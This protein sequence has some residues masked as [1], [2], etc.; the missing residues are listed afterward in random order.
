[1]GI[2]D[3][4]AGA[5]VGIVKADPLALTIIVQT[6]TSAIVPSTKSNT[7]GFVTK[8]ADRDF[9]ACPAPKPNILPSLKP[10]PTC[11]YALEAVFAIFCGLT[12]A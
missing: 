6:T 2:G 12:G 1:M 8:R 4:V 11:P 10:V 7:S 9:P 3:G 5:D